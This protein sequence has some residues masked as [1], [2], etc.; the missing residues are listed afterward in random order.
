MH[1]ADVK[2]RGYLAKE[3]CPDCVQSALGMAVHPEDG[4]VIRVLVEHQHGQEGVEIVQHRA[5]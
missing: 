2:L 4:D 3:R 5:I 1:Q